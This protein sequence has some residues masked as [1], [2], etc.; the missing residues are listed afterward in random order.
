MLRPHRRDRDDHST[1]AIFRFLA[2][3]GDTLDG[4]PGAAQETA[5]IE[6]GVVGPDGALLAGARVELRQPSSQETRTAVVDAGGRYRFE[7]LPA[8]DYLLRVSAPGLET[9][10]RTVNVAA[11][12]PLVVDVELSLEPFEQEIEVVAA[13]GYARSLEELPV[14]ATVVTREEVLVAPAR[15]V[16]GLLR[17]VASVQARRRGARGEQRPC[18]R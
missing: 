4:E 6:G 13:A 14:S 3:A 8:G 5:S 16:D 9:V 2:S 7:G 18:G 15:S 1:P 10:E 12:S 11:G 17:H